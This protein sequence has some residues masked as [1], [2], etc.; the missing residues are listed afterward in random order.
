MIYQQSSIS[1]KAIDLWQ[2][3]V[4]CKD[5]LRERAGM[6]TPVLFSGHW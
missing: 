5:L 2:Y 3:S 6:I 4:I 1:F